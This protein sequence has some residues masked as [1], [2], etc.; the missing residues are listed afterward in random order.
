M[1]KIVKKILMGAIT[2]VFLIC[3]F[4]GCGKNTQNSKKDVTVT[5][6]NG[7]SELGKVTVKEGE[8]IAKA[9]YEKYES[10]EGYEFDGWYA[11]PT[12]LEASKKDLTKDTFTEDLALY[13]VFKSTNVAEDTRAWYIVGA[14]DLGSLSDSSWAGSGVE[15]TVREQFRLQPTGKNTNEFAITIDLFEGD[16]FQ[17][18]YDWQWTGQKGFGC[19]TE[20]DATQMENGGGLGGS[21]ATSNINVIMSG[22]YTITLTTDPNNSLMD[23]LVIVRNGDTLG[24]GVEKEEEPF[25]FTD[26]TGVMIKGSWVSDWSDVKALTRN[27]DTTEFTVT[28]ELAA[29]TELCFMV[30]ED[31]NDTGIVLK[32]MHVVDDASKALLTDNLNNVQVKE[33]GNYTF[34]VDPVN[35][36]VVVTK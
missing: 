1:K 28:M 12:F 3:A 5:F 29:D 18:I 30:Y 25:V 2:G 17:I 7:D 32:A 33:A 31:G 11:T 16:Q 35:M 15:E 23:T 4:C 14:S 10:V 13:G 26:K 34:T 20:I 9:D 36:T 24:E 21:D 19:F 27:G 8:L 22:N 6:M